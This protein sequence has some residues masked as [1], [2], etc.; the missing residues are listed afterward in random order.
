MQTVEFQQALEQLIQTAQE[1]PTA[2]MC[3]EAVEWRCHRSLVSDALLVRGVDVRHIHDASTP[4]PHRL[5]SFAQV[6]GTTV[7]YPSPDPQQHLEYD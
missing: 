5:T 7:T 3:A 6:R 4:K 2:I 1:Q